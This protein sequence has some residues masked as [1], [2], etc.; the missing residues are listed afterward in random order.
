LIPDPGNVVLAAAA[1]DSEAGAHYMLSSGIAD[2]YEILGVDDDAPTE[3]IKKAYRALA[4]EC[5]PDILGDEKGHEICI[6][7]NEVGST[8]QSNRCCLLLLL[9]LLI[10]LL[11]CCCCC[12]CAPHGELLLHAQAYDVL[13]D[14]ESRSRYDAQLDKAL[15]DEDAGYTGMH[16]QTQTLCCTS[17]RARFR[18]DTT[19][20][21]MH[22]FLTQSTLF[23]TSTLAMLVWICL[24]PSSTHR[25][26]QRC[27]RNE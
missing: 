7:L 22:L 12:W 11:P 27:P 18:T 15:A 26:V 25:N 21:D 8:V 6:L 14:P 1:S 13:S 3:E 17:A 24:T 9:L 20:A 10:L 19:H 23:G 2:F 16:A 4:K 5:H